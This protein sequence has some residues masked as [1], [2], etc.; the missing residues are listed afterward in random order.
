MGNFKKDGKSEKHS[1]LVMMSAF[2]KITKHL[3][4]TLSAEMSQTSFIRFPSSSNP[5]EWKGFLTKTSVTYLY[6]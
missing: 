5:F 3:P 4:N 1:F 2:L 6:L